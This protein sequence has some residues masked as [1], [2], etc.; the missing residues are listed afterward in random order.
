MKHELCLVPAEQLPIASAKKEILDPY[1]K[2]SKTKDP[3][4]KRSKT[5]KE[6]LLALAQKM[7][8][9]NADNVNEMFEIMKED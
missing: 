7:A 4:P 5:K 8:R 2:R 9:E 3:Y 6:R 1:P